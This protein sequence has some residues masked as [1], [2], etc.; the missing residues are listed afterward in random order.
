M[1]ARWAAS[2]GLMLV[3]IR[4]FNA[5]GWL[6]NF[7]RTPHKLP[8]NGDR[9]LPVE[10]HESRNGVRLYR[11]VGVV[12][13]LYD[14]CMTFSASMKGATG[15]IARL[16]PTRDKRAAKVGEPQERVLKCERDKSA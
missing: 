6:A 12:S 8:R 3:S 14:A 2:R 13:G 10:A 16:N 15:R 5:E 9:F 4:A 11:I 7:P 1:P